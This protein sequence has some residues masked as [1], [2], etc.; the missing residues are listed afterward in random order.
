MPLIKCAECGKEIS[1]KAFSCPH[2]G[3]PLNEEEQ[4][5]NPFRP[6]KV[7]LNIEKFEITDKKWKKYYALGIPLLAIGLPLFF[8]NL[9]MGVMGSATGVAS[10]SSAGW[11]LL[12]L[13]FSGIGGILCLIAL[14]GNWWQR[15]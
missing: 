14:I 6:K 5:N 2:C 7:D 1:D 4:L 11:F 3:A 15:G 9:M 13:L 10:T 8:Y 12:G